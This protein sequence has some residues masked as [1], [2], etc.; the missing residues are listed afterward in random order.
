MYI[1]VPSNNALGVHMYTEFGD[2]LSGVPC[3]CCLFLLVFANFY[4]FCCLLTRT[5]VLCCKM[6]RK[7]TRIQPQP[8]EEAVGSAGEDASVTLTSTDVMW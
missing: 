8:P 7:R 6:S 5:L 1:R 3:H 2:A 4:G